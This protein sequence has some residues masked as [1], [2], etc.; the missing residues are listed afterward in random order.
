MSVVKVIVLLGSLSK[1]VPL[2]SAVTTSKYI[3]ADINP[4]TLAEVIWEETMSSVSLHSTSLHAVLV[5]ISSCVSLLLIVQ[6]E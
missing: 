4:V 1:L 2:E 3:K 5:S 6:F